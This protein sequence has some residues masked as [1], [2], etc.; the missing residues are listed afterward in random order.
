[1]SAVETKETNMRAYSL[2][3]LFRLTRTELLALHAK[4]VTELASLPETCTDREIALSNLRNIRRVLT[5]FTIA[6]H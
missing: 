4:I 5:K 2:K 6:P 1:M 3:E